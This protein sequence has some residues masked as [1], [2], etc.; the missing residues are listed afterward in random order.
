MIEMLVHDGDGNIVA[1]FNSMSIPE[2]IPKHDSWLDLGDEVDFDDINFPTELTDPY[3]IKYQSNLN[4]IADDQDAIVLTETMN[5]P[6]QY[7]VEIETQNGAWVRNIYF[8]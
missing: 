2:N 7:E 4:N 3:V 5:A 8:P 1:T 6:N